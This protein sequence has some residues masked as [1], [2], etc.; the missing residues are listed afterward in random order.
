MNVYSI[1]L[2]ESSIDENKELINKCADALSKKI[3]AD[4]T[5]TEKGNQTI[6]SYKMKDDK[7]CDVVFEN[8]DEVTL[9]KVKDS[10]H[11]EIQVDKVIKRFTD[12]LASPVLR[13][14][15]DH[16]KFVKMDESRS[17]INREVFNKLKKR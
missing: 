1:F 17:R 11:R 6:I 13:F 8:D 14:L 3:D 9:K 12:A 2:N 10:G 4:Y 15:V 7:V 16:N 5:I